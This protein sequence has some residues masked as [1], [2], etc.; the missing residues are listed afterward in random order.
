MH[1]NQAMLERI[2]RYLMKNMSEDERS[3]FEEE[4][5]KD[6]NLKSQL[7]QMQDLLMGLNRIAFKVHIKKA[8]QYYKN[9]I[10][11][12]YVGIALAGLVAIAS[13]YWAIHIYLVP[14]TI[15]QKN[16]QNGTEPEVVYQEIVTKDS[17]SIK[18][19]L[20]KIDTE[21]NAVIES[22]SGIIVGIPKSCLLDNLGKPVNG[23]VF[24]GLREAIT[25]AQIVLAG[26]ETKNGNNILE[27]GGMFHLSAYQNGVE[28]Q[29]DSTKPIIVKV[30][31]SEEKEGMQLYKGEITKE[32]GVNWVDPKP[33]DQSLIPVDILS[34][35]FY[36][37]RLIP[38]MK[39]HGLYKTDKTYTDSIY[40][41]LS[42]ELGQK[43][44]SEGDSYNDF[45]IV[46]IAGATIKT[47]WDNKFNNTLLATNDFEYRLK[48][49]HNSC[50]DEASYDFTNDVL[51]L[52]IN[53]L[54]KNLYEIDL[55]AAKVLRGPLKRQFESLARLKKGKLE[56]SKGLAAELGVYFAKRR[57]MN[58]K[59]IQEARN[60]YLVNYNKQ[61]HDF[62]V[63]KTLSRD[64]IAENAQKATLHDIE[65]NRKNVAKQLG[66]NSNLNIQVMLTNQEE[67][68]Q[69]YTARVYS[70]GWNNIDRA[71]S[72]VVINA[73]LSKTNIKIQIGGKTSKIIYNDLKL[74]VKHKENFEK[75]SSYLIPSNANCFIKMQEQKPYYTDQ[76]NADIQYQTVVIGESNGKRYFNQTKKQKPGIY[77]VKLKETSIDEI[78]KVLNGQSLK[79]TNLFHSFEVEAE[80]LAKAKEFK[81]AKQAQEVFC[82]LQKDVFPCVM[83]RSEIDG[84]ALFEYNCKS[85]H[86]INHQVVG[87]A[88]RGV[89]TRHSREWIVEWVSNPQGMISKKD[90]DAVK[91]YEQYKT[92]GVMSAFFSNLEPF[93]RDH[94]IES[95]INYI[96]GCTTSDEQLENVQP[97][98][99][100]SDTL[101]KIR[102]RFGF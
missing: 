63:S 9:L 11:L 82:R 100:V 44:I 36:P 51:N 72:E 87:P 16:E 14:S 20:F 102:V 34:L 28:L 35:D 77:E 73:S 95:I 69:T 42:T 29:L 7:N 71:L 47:I 15:G 79:L 93:E 81:K 13:I 97:K 5:E 89:S 64:I 1:D 17:I 39:Q 58:E 49:L 83:R 78:K 53:N 3:T 32:G 88:L 52:Y 10:T 86:A 67:G 31:T 57:L 99:D 65:V 50:N 19:Q 22:E 101:K 33:L 98:L 43:P 70:F 80:V 12:K 37:P 4:L 84:K 18:T 54:D 68:I 74:T 62:N 45:K 8:K 91:L 66:V 24:I 30:P 55:M 60:S 6:G 90:P 96:D 94:T 40:Y 41:A 46:G 21:A 38:A 92:A 59:I 61:L 85:C 25:P 23:Q 48:L 76:M 75:I 26:L 27:T 2:E 56:V